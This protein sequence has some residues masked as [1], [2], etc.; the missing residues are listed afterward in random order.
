MRKISITFT[1]DA[2]DASQYGCKLL[3]TKVPEGFELI[4]TL[5]KNLFAGTF[6]AKEK[7]A[8]PKPKPEAPKAEAPQQDIAAM[9]A[10]A[11]AQAMAAQ[12]K[13]ATPKKVAK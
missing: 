5:K 1:F 9:I 13:P 11:V 3:E 12:A 4:G 8:T 6:P 7:T 2:D 10:A